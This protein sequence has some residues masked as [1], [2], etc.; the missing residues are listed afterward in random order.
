MYITIFFFRLTYLLCTFTEVIIYDDIFIY[1]FVYPCSRKLYWRDFTYV[2]LRFFG[3]PSS[4]VILSIFL[5]SHWNSEDFAGKVAQWMSWLVEY[6]FLLSR[7]FCS[8]FSFFFPLSL[9]L[10]SSFIKCILE[11]MCVQSWG[12]PKL[13]RFAIISLFLY[14]AWQ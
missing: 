11:V 12:L 5:L 10:S 13:I 9:S 1:F 7:Y 2:D 14:K 3:I 8:H 4:Y 6:L